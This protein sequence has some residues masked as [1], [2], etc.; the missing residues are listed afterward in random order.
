MNNVT[1]AVA[2]FTA[3][4]GQAGAHLTAGGA[5][6]LAAGGVDL[7][8]FAQGDFVITAARLPAPFLETARLL[9]MLQSLNA[10]QRRP[11]EPLV[12]LAQ[13]GRASELSLIATVRC[14][15]DA[16]TASILDHGAQA[17][18]SFRKDWL[19]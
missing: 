6:S 18:A 15:A 12:H 13:V 7:T 4:H 1:N 10:R 5:V 19:P 17:L 14:P 3:R 16:V 9:A 8:L 11:D 2:E